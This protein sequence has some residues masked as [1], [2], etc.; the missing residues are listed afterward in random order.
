MTLAWPTDMPRCLDYPTTGIDA[1]LAGAARAYPDRIALQ[2]GDLELT[3]AE[4]YD[5]AQ[6]AAGGLRALGVQP[7]DVVAL[8]GRT[9]WARRSHRAPKGCP[10]GRSTAGRP[11][12]C[13]P[14]C[15]PA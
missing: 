7:G 9:G 15:G 6:R 4:L 2:D 13:S 10:S 11:Y 14:R 1:V 8:C 12:G 5:R 3:F